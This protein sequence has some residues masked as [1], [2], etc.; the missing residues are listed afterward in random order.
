MTRIWT[1]ATT[2][3]RLLEGK[4]AREGQEKSYKGLG[5]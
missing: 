1:L 3:N 2:H 5:H 4:S